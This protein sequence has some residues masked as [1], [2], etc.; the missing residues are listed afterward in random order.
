MFLAR[1][2]DGNE[3]GLGREPEEGGSVV[4]VDEERPKEVVE[5]GNLKKALL[6]V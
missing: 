6:H 2:I 4:V 1:A 3:W 5:I